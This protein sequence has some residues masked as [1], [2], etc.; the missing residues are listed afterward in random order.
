MRSQNKK[1]PPRTKIYLP[2]ALVRTAKV[3]LARNGF[4]LSGWIRLLVRKAVAR[5]QASLK[6]SR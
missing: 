3:H 5:S 6:K 1:S 4:T 2:P